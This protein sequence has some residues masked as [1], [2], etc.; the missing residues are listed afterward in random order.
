VALNHGAPLA[1]YV[2]DF[3]AVGIA[4][5]YDN[6]I[7]HIA[8]GKHTQQLAALVD[9]ADRADISR[10]HELRCFLHG[11]RVPGRVRL[12]VPDHVPDKH[13]FC[14]LILLRGQYYNGKS[15]TDYTDS[16]LKTEKPG[17]SGG[18]RSFRWGSG[19]CAF[20]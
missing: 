4:L 3:H 11:S 13:R 9:Y 7:Q 12:T 15:A 18:E 2:S 20:C 17:R 8:L 10:R 1:G 5:R 6:A 14:L 16:Q 19:A